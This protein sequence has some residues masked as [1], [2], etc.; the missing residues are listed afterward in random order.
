MIA[1]DYAARSFMAPRPRPRAE[2][3]RAARALKGAWLTDTGLEHLG[4]K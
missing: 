4:A 1:G 2:R 3:L